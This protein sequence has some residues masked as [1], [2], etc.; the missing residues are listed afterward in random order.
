MINKIQGAYTNIHVDPS[1]WK[2]EELLQVWKSLQGH[3]F[4]S[5][6]LKASAINLFR[7][8][9]YHFA[10]DLVGGA[11]ISDPDHPGI[12]QV[13]LY[14]DA[15]KLLPNGNGQGASSLQNFEG[16]IIHELAHVA[17]HENPFIVESHTL[18]SN[19][20]DYPDNILLG[21]TFG[22][23]YDFSQCGEGCDTE[24]IAMAASTWQLMPQSFN[25]SFFFI[26]YVDWHESW[27]GSFY[28][29]NLLA[30]GGYGDTYIGAP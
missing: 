21:H 14:D 10:G 17:M 4:I 15:Y 9:F 8:A 29:P 1:R 2:E 18:R 27:I 22:K 26:P 6:I 25:G 24:Q 23:A 20:A 19:L 3:V 11:T 5:D 12:Y 13:T 28:T 16:T 7:Q 30:P